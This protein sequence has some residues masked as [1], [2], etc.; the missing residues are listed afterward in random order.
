MAI[1]LQKGQTINLRKEEHALSQVTIGLGWDIR[2]EKPKRGLFSSLLGSKTDSDFDLDAVAVLLNEH[3]KI[4]EVGDKNLVNGDVVFFNN[5]KHRSGYIWHTGD[6]RTGDGDGDDEQI[7]V[8]LE[9][10]FKQFHKILFL[11]SIYQGQ[12]KNQHFGLLDNAYIR[13]VDANGKEMLKYNLNQD[14]DYN[15]MCTMLFGEVYRRDGDWKFR[16]I[17]QA[18]PEDSF[19]PI[20]KRYL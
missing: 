12:Q 15:G 10:M 19:V 2:Q 3:D 17:G 11:V 9:R 4:I 7:I 6:N 8:N 14:Q 5:L 16:A 18:F 1:N 20:V 13:A